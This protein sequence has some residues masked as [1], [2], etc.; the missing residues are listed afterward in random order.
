VKVPFFRHGLR[1]SDAQAVSK[2]L[3]GPFLTSGETGRHVEELLVEFFDVPFAL[4]GSS[5]TNTATAVLMALDLKPG[6]KVI[7]PAQTFV[8]TAN[9]VEL[10]GAQCIFVDVDADTL[11]LTPEAVKAAMTDRVRAVIPVNLYG[12]MADIRGIREAVGDN[13]AIIEDC[14]HCFEGARD[15]YLPGQQSDAAIFS[16]YATKNITCGEG[17]AVVTKREDLHLA[18]RQSMLHG[19][20][21]SARERFDAATHVHWDMVRLGTKSSLSEIHASLLGPQI[22]T[23]RAKLVRREEIA[24]EYSRAFDGTTIQFPRPC[25]NAVHAR[26]LFPI[27]VPPPMR[28]NV[29]RR[30]RDCGIGVTVNYVAVPR[31][32]Y[33]RKKYGFNEGDFPV[34][35]RWGNGTISL[36]LFPGLRP[37]EQ[38]YIIETIRGQIIPII[39]G[40]T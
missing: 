9:A 35:E 32:S 15:G 13:V 19:I 6:D 38:R 8:A 18:I 34:S 37:A 22:K 5:W 12:L 33:Y 40:N 11:L 17:G 27:F 20:S 31:T 29:L 1:A 21:P 3:N 39:D 14:A 25:E 23:I 28:D 24:Q 16:F 10:V 30:L 4:L 7:V 36:P 2:V 26:H